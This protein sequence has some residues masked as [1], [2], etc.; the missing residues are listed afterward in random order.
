MKH[1]FFWTREDLKIFKSVIDFAKQESGHKCDK[2]TVEELIECLKTANE[3]TSRKGCNDCPSQIE[4]L[5]T[6]KEWSKIWVEF[7]HYNGD[8]EEII[9]KTS[10]PLPD[11]CLFYYFT[12]KLKNLNTIP[13]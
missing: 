1:N 5:L 9:E 6:S 3:K 12:T 2:N 11:F 13:Q 10:H 7:H 4:R 8:I